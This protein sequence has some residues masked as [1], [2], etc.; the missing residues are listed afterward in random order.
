VSAEAG[1]TTRVSVESGSVVLRIHGQAAL[2]LGAG[3][4]WNPSQRA[5]VAACASCEPT[6]VPAAPSPALTPPS[7]AVTSP[8][9]SSTSPMG[10]TRVPSASASPARAASPFAS[11]SATDREPNPSLDFR[12]AMTALDS[13]DNVAAAARFAS[14]LSAHPQDARC[15]DAAYLRVI[16]L[17]RSGDESSM[18]RAAAHYLRQYPHGFRHAEVAAL[19][20]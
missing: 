9:A 13:G 19:A 14:F 6:H 16:A 2:A 12:A 4:L 3:E 15:E 8:M 11:A 18:R 10:S 20:D 17:Q 1:R 5:A 7:P